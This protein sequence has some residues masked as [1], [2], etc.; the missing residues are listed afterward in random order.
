VYLAASVPGCSLPIGCPN[1]TPTSAA[2][3]VIEAQGGFSTVNG[4]SVGTQIRFS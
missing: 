3:Y 4:I 2:N 1:Y